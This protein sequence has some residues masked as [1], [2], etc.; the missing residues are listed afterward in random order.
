MAFMAGAMK[1]WKNLA[2]EE[3]F[4]ISGFWGLG[5]FSEKLFSPRQRTSIKLST[6]T[7]PQTMIVTLPLQ[8]Q[9]PCVTT[10]NKLRPGLV[11]G[12]ERGRCFFLHL[13]QALNPLHH[14]PDALPFSSL[15]TRS[16]PKM[17][18]CQGEPNNQVPD[19]PV[20]CSSE[21]RLSCSLAYTHC[22]KHF[23][24]YQ[25]RW[26]RPEALS[27]PS[28]SHDRYTW[29]LTGRELGRPAHLQHQKSGKSPC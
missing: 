9:L 5:P 8:S 21:S 23:L 1:T 3:S 16:C 26:S 18:H 27:L 24:C 13:L 22:Q 2:W 28:Q 14:I 7:R 12:W 15:T 25:N 17:A 20:D 10:S 6:V 19:T 11:E 29:L 4:F